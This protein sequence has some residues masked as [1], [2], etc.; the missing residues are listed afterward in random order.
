[1][2]R[3]WV[4]G[5]SDGSTGQAI[6]QAGHDWGDYDEVLETDRSEV[7]IEDWREIE[8]Y[9]SEHAPIDHIVYAAGIAQLQ[10][11]RDVGTRDLHTMFA[12][13]TFG[14]VGL[15]RSLLT[16]QNVGRVLAIISDATRTPMRGSLAYCASKSALEMAVRCAARELAPTWK[17]NGISPSVIGE[18]NMTRTMDEEVPTFRGWSSEDTLAYEKSSV[19]MGRR[20][21]KREVAE[22]AMS[23]LN[24][25][26]F[27]TGSIIYL[28]GGK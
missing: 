10:W 20:A 16:H 28:T 19:P 21:E 1:M 7:D 23:T 26:E 22:L 5:S 9:V 6:A 3:L 17:I 13:N 2:K 4:I 11:I 15:L 8:G 18:T 25:P 27:L 12:T 14:F 24:G